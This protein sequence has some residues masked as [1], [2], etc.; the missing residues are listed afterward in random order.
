MW[1]SAE[2]IGHIEYQP[3]VPGAM[4]TT[5]TKWTEEMEHRLR[6]LVKKYEEKW[7]LIAKHF[8]AEGISQQAL[9]S[10]AQRRTGKI[11]MARPHGECRSVA[12]GSLRRCGWPR[13]VSIR[14]RSARFSTPQPHP[15]STDI[16]PPLPPHP[17]P[18]LLAHRPTPSPTGPN[19]PH[20]GYQWTFNLAKTFS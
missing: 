12:I 11:P 19:N 9:C 5:H 3:P 8:E 7:S 15:P 18:S 17:H 2:Y 16:S 6:R 20:H 4:K 1:E 13:K 10:T 14:S